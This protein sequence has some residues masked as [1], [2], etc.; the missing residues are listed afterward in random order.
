MNAEELF[1]RAYGL[2]KRTLRVVRLHIRNLFATGR[3]KK[4]LRLF[5]DQPLRLHV[6]CGPILLGDWVNL[7]IDGHPDI[8]VD[9]TRRLPFG[10][11]SVSHVFSEHVIEH[12][13]LEE[14]SHCFEEFARVLAKGGVVRVATIDLDHVI[15]KY[16][17][18]WQNQKWLKTDGQDIRTRTQMLNASF[19]RWGHRFIYNEEELRILL[20]SAGFSVVTRRAWGESDIQLLQGLERREESTLIMEAGKA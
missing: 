18:D 4:K 17:R 14:A 16:Q 19:Y 11:G 3:R 10:D 20:L 8:Y 6:G 2:L 1:D 12:L 5:S 7:D 15:S 9:L 13:S